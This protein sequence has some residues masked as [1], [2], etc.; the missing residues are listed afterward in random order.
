MAIIT[1]SVFLFVQ[2]S[3][4]NGF[5]LN[6]WRKS[7]FFHIFFLESIMTDKGVSDR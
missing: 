2:K 7:K 4:L 1:S 6:S 3:E 5:V